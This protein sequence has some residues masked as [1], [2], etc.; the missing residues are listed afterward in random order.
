[1]AATTLTPPDTDIT[2]THDLEW[3]PPMASSAE[4]WTCARCKRTVIRYHGNVYGDGTE[5]ACDLAG[6]LWDHA[7]VVAT[8]AALQDAGRDIYTAGFST[9]GRHALIVDIDGDRVMVAPVGTMHGLG[10]WECSKRH[11]DDH[12]DIYHGRFPLR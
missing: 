7:P 4:R 8:V 11:Y 9:D 1:M 12:T 5:N 6:W 10:R 2:R 3:D